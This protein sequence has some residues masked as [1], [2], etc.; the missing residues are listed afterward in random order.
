M[1]FTTSGGTGGGGIIIPA[2]M[3]LFHFDAPSSIAISNFSILVSGVVRIVLNCNQSH[4]LKHGT[5][6]IT[7]YNI[8]SLMLPGIIFGASI[9]AVVNLALPG[10]IQCTGFV[11]CNTVI[12]GSA[13]RNFFKI[14]SQEKI[15]NGQK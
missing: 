1:V 13:L 7:D 9:G 2:M 14:R 12:V 15:G 10:P 3:A 11:I 8:A 4:P 6:T 5:G